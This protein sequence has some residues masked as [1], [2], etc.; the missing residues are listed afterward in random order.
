M[1]TAVILVATSF[2]AACLRAAPAWAC[3][4]VLFQPGIVLDGEGGMRLMSL[5]YKQSTNPGDA[6]PT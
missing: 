1:L 2:L 4:L 3:V 6:H 5:E